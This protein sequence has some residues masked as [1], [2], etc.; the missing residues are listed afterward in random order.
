[1]KAWTWVA[2]GL[3]VICLLLSSFFLL[4]RSPEVYRFLMKTNEVYDRV[5]L[6]PSEIDKAAEVI[7][8]Y[9][10]GSEP[11]LLIEHEGDSLF[12]AQEVFHMY[13]VRRIFS[14][15]RTIL[16]FCGLV[17]FG[18]VF[19]LGNDR[20]W[21]LRKQLYVMLG[22]SAVIGVASL[23][24]D[25]AFFWMHQTLFNNLFWAFRADHMLIQLLPTGFFLMFLVLTGVLSL[26]LSITL[27]FASRNYLP[28]EE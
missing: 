6:T 24:F 12:K 20:W 9:M 15:M 13:E 3:L 17:F 18:F 26:V 4:V 25:K 14:H 1:M 16:I 2:A 19:L 22:L 23:F 10:V 27:F 21:V 7:A 11:H 28:Q 5:D 8:D